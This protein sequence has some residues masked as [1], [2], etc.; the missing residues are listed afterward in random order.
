MTWHS[1]SRQD[2]TIGSMSLQGETRDDKT[3]LENALFSRDFEM[4][5][6]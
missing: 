2:K 1:K 6:M 5:D 3:R 4:E